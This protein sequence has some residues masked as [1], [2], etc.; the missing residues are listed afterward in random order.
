MA[1]RDVAGLD[2]GIGESHIAILAN[3]SPGFTAEETLDARK[4]CE[5]QQNALGGLQ[6]SPLSRLSRKCFNTFSAGI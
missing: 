3:A 2:R 6:M 4:A 1:L 5:E